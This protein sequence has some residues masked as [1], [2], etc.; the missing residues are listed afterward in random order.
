MDGTCI[1]ADPGW[2]G[3]AASR[4][5]TPIVRTK[6]GQQFMLDRPGCRLYYWRPGPASAPTESSIGQLRPPCLDTAHESDFIQDSDQ[7]PA[8][9]HLTKP[10]G[11]LGYSRTRVMIVVKA[12][13]GREERK[14]P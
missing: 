9:V 10:C 14:N 1:T 12:F 3:R 8:R 4:S 7:V 11:E 5:A 2:P 13:A 6:Y